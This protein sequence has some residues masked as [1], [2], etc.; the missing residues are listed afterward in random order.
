MATDGDPTDADFSE[1]LRASR[2]SIANAF[3]VDLETRYMVLKKEKESLEEER[4]KHQAQ[5]FELLEKS[6]TLEDT[7]LARDAELAAAKR[8]KNTLQE[9]T[10]NHAEEKKTQQERMNRME[11]E[12]DSLREESRYVGREK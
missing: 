10:V 5:L 9:E 8:D 4:T 12:A 1:A 3:A 7:L 11:A 6:K 2:E